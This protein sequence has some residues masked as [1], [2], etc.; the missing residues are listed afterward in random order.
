MSTPPR[1]STP[2]P[3]RQIRGSISRDVA[4]N[5]RVARIGTVLFLLLACLAYQVRVLSHSLLAWPSSPQ[6]A[7]H[8]AVYIARSHAETLAAVYWTAATACSQY[9]L[10]NPIT[11]KAEMI[12]ALVLVSRQMRVS[13]IPHCRRFLTRNACPPPLLCS[14]LLYAIRVHL[15][16]APPNALRTL[17]ST[18]YLSWFA[19]SCTRMTSVHLHGEVQVALTRIAACLVCLPM[20]SSALLV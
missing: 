18:P 12:S 16:P 15:T 5:Y 13:M 10:N 9:P 11:Q 7:I 3:G 19:F 14:P 17:P 2:L 20:A 1:L 6:Y 8:S 4:I